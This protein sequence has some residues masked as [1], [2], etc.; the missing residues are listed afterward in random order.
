MNYRHDIED[1]LPGRKQLTVLILRLLRGQIKGA[2]SP[3]PESTPSLSLGV[4]EF[5]LMCCKF[6]A[7]SHLLFFSRRQIITVDTRKVTQKND[8]ASHILNY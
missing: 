2:A 7:F 1:E 4:I 8:D 6:A 5:P 3:W